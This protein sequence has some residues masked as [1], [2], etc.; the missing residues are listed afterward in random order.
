M[1]ATSTGHFPTSF[2]IVPWC[3]GDQWG[4]DCWWRVGGVS[5]L[6]GH[7]ALNGGCANGGVGVVMVF[8]VFLAVPALRQEM[9]VRLVAFVKSSFVGSPSLPEL[10]CE[11]GL[12]TTRPKEGLTSISKDCVN[13][14]VTARSLVN[15][16]V[17]DLP[18]DGAA[19]L[20]VLQSKLQTVLNI[21]KSFIV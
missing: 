5:S 9:L 21:D 8:V 4:G 18:L 6:G 10:K 20:E 7:Y 14:F 13:D 12:F 19:I 15:R 3:G 2:M 1:Q 11:I 16:M 17:Q